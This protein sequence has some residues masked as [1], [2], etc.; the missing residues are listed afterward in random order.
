M[1][2]T[3]GLVPY[4]VLREGYQSVPSNLMSPVGLRS[5]FIREISMQRAQIWQINNISLVF[6]FT[7]PSLFRLKEMGKWPPSSAGG[8]GLCLPSN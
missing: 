2:V 1:D 4:F 5:P 8:G 6:L 7:A 3:R